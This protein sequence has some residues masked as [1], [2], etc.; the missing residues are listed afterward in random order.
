MSVPINDIADWQYSSRALGADAVVYS[1]GV[2]D[3]IDFDCHLIDTHAATVHA[4]DPTP[5]AVEWLNQKELP[6]N[7]HFHQWAVAALDG[8]LTMQPRRHKA[9]TKPA[10]MW[11]AVDADT[12]VD[13]N[14]RVPTYS[15]ATIMRMLEHERIDLLKMDI[16]GLEY[17]VIE[18]IGSLPHKPDQLLIEFHHRFA[19]IGIA[20]TR[21]ALAR[22]KDMG[23][24]VFAVSRTGREVG[25]IQTGAVPLQPIR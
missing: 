17:E 21:A 6:E 24:Q 10:V 5:Y 19:R 4:F 15:I 20:A 12:N 13:E 18:S 9:N 1:F 3:N 23:Y 11:T 14:I 8:E 2:G 25:F 16:E 22:L 7:F